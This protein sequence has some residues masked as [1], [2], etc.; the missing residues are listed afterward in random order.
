MQKKNKEER[1]RIDHD[2]ENK[3]VKIIFSTTKHSDISEQE[4]PA[5]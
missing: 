1:A 4:I 5:R 2:G 3:F